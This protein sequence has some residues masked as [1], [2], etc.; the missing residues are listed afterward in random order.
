M[1]IGRLHGVIP[2]ESKLEIH[3]TAGASYKSPFC[4]ICLFQVLGFEEP[5]HKGMGNQ[6]SQ[7][8]EPNNP[9]AEG[10]QHD[11]QAASNKMQLMI[12]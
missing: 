10:C 8:I 2:N 3:T 1:E 9:S 5:S 12:F 6:V 4:I 11:V 7:K